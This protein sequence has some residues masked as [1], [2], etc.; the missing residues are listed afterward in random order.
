MV[1][2]MDFP[3]VVQH[4]NITLKLY[5]WMGYPK[6]KAARNVEAFDQSGNLLWVIESLGGHA[7]TDCYTSI[8]SR[9]RKIHA[10]NFQGY[11]CIVDEV[12]G[13]VLSSLFTK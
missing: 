1:T 2:V 10:F 4:K 9:D 6:G 11:D 5:N 3:I 7:A 8:S 13:K 12:S